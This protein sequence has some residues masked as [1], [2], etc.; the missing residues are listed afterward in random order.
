MVVHIAFS[1]LTIIIVQTLYGM[2]REAAIG[3]FLRFPETGQVICIK[4][5]DQDT[6]IE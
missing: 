6:L 5:S 1:L 4:C 2:S 3:G